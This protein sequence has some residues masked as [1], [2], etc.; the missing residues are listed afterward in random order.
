MQRIDVQG[1]KRT[2]GQRE[3]QHNC[4]AG[5][6]ENDAGDPGRTFRGEVECRLC[7]IFNRAKSLQRVSLGKRR[8][9]RFGYSLP[10]AFC[11]DSFRSDAV[12]TIL[13]GPTCA[14][15]CRVSMMM[16]AFAAA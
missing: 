2:E 13:K 15:R 12:D 3:S 7:D 4:P 6:I 1:H 5:D 16:P 9:L 10:V 14:A 8:L 11:K